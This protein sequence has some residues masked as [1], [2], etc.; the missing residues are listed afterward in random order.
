MYFM[1]ECKGSVYRPS[2]RDACAKPLQM[3]YASGQPGLSAPAGDGACCKYGGATQD[4]VRPPTCTL[5]AHPF[6]SARLCY[7]IR[8]ATTRAPSSGTLV[9]DRDA[10]QNG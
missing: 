1:V 9:V 10:S 7:G 2:R 5:L 3:W 4:V 6:I 8:A